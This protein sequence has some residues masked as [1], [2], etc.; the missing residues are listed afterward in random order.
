MAK[1][2]SE[3]K[4]STATSRQLPGHNSDYDYTLGWIKEAIDARRPQNA[5]LERAVMAYQGQP[6]VNRY[7]RTI[8]NYATEVRK[9]DSVKAKD[10]ETYCKDIPEK[11][12]MVIHNAVETLVSM[13]MGGVG[14]YEFGP[15]DADLQKD[16]DVMDRLASAA[17]SFYIQNHVDAI[18]PQYVRN[19]ILGGAS[20]M[21]LKQR[22][23]KKVLTLLSS[24]QMLT[25]PK[26]FKTNFSRFIGFSQ[27]ESFS[28][29]KNRT[30]KIKGG[31]YVLKTLNEADVY[32]QMIR[33][34]MNSVL[35]SSGNGTDAF[36][37]DALSADLNT[38]YKPI[39]TRLQ[40]EKTSS[41]TDNPNTM[42]DGDEIEMTYLYD[43]M[44]DMYFEIVN[45]RYIIVAKTN[46]LKRDI[47]CTYFDAD[48]NKKT[49]TKTVKL[50]NPF[51]ELPYTRTFWDT[52][53][54]TPIFYLLD[55]FDDVCAME[56]VLYHNLSIMAPLTFVGQSSDSAKV[57]RVA[58]VAGEIVEGLP[59]TF[60]VLSKTHDIT[61][62]VTGIQR[63]EEKI[64]RTMNAVDPF[65]LQAMIGD[66]ATAKEVVSA[67]GQVAQGINQFLANIE[68]AFAVLGD[69][70]FK[71]ELIMS[72]GNYTF[73]HNGTYSEVSREEMAGDYEISAK[74]VTSIKLELEANSRKALELIQY[75]NGNEALDMRQFLGATMPIVLTGL[76]RREQAEN[77]ILPQYRPM[78][79]EVIAAIKRR[80]EENAKKDEIDKLDLSGYDPEQLDALNAQFGAAY[81]D[82]NTDFSTIPTAPAVDPSTGQAMQMPAAPSVTASI[83]GNVMPPSA[84][85][86]SSEQAGVVANDP[87]GGGYVA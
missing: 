23:G 86:P 84:P 40:T 28:V 79:D 74:L 55:D 81:G 54:I 26:R 27:R 43:E 21:H 57:S 50:D 62:V 61:P 6:S 31:G 35:N 25:D 2:N 15:Y 14:Q 71:L 77:M 47:K 83:P 8:R 68:T 17:K 4:A 75:L 12:S 63:V 22:N 7:S 16:P 85:T 42:Y 48:G 60:G 1:S 39:I 9:Y 11:G 76:L 46:P 59:Q 80:A 67:S 30:R 33:Q 32:V 37:H 49:K 19:A 34:E 24:D 78:P 52:Y 41:S 44:N 29:V 13:A 56:S 18:V 66:R 87:T 72:E 5:L 20:Y 3:P 65:E 10:I 45:R 53:P 73:S 38:F 36:M 64:K 82:P 58:S 70:F 69:K 51:I